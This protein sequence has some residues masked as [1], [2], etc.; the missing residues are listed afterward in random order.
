MTRDFTVLLIVPPSVVEVD[1]AR[2]AYVPARVDGRDVVGAGRQ[3]PIEA[4]MQLEPLALRT[5]SLFA[6]GLR[7]GELRHA[8]GGTRLLH[9]VQIDAEPRAAKTRSEAVRW[10]AGTI[11]DSP[12][13]VRSLRG[14]PVGARRPASEP[15]FFGVSTLP[16]DHAAPLGVLG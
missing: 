5:Q 4:L 16:R 9:E 13:A 8:R 10:P 1:Q 6:A 3:A 2:V 7:E 12:S 14:Y 15:G 11:S